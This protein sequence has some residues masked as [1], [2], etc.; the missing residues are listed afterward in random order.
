[1]SF[2]LGSLSKD[3]APRDGV[4]EFSAPRW[5]LQF[6]VVFGGVLWLLALLALATHSGN[7]PAWST[8]GMADEMH[9]RAGVLG[10]WFADIAFFLFGYSVWWALLIAGRAWLSAL[11]KLLRAEDTPARNDVVA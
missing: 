1:M 11:A 7:D 3:A 5:R 2:P 10:A 6:A 4:A 9:N 8:S